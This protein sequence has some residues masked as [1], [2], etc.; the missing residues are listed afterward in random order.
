MADRADNPREM[1]TCST[2]RDLPGQAPHVDEAPPIRAI[3][4]IKV[5]RLT[6]KV[7]HAAALDMPPLSAARIEVT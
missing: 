6:P 5:V 4:S 2:N 3:V 1:A 7:R